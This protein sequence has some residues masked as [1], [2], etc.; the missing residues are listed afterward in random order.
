MSRNFI[1]F[2][3]LLLVGFAGLVFMQRSAQQSAPDVQGSNNVYGNLDSQVTLT[4]Y[5][6]F[7]CEACYAFY[8][9]VKEVKEKYKD[10]VKFQ[11]KYF[12][13]TS[14]HQHALAAAAT[15]QAAAKQGKFFEMHDLLFE[16]QKSWE[17]SQNRDEVFASYAKEIGL[18]MAKFNEDVT[19]RE[20][21]AIINADLEEVQKLGGNGTPT[22]ALNGEKIDNPD[23]TVEA[24]SKLLDT[25]LAETE[26]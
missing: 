3:S 2:I 9:T 11:I 5:V 13:I 21:Q 18:D 25:A 4:E 12:P 7:Q 14:S 20:T 10:R 26:N 6:D 24:F 15:A 17:N 16:R 19:S 22:F 1:I 23:N 8:P